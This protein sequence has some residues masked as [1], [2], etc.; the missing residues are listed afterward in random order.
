MAAT[1]GAARPALPGYEILESLGSGGMGEVYR[2]CQESL[3][4]EV[5]VKILRADVPAAGWLPERFEQEAR[6]M[7]GLH[8]PRV[9]TVHDCVRLDD[10]RVAIVMELVGGG[11]L[12][13][14]LNA[15]PN[16]L[17]LEQ[18][19]RW[20]REI[21]EG[22]R[23]AH[24]AGV[25][26]RDV[27]PDNVL[28][29][30]TG[31]ARVSDFGMAFSPLPDAV[32]FTQTGMAAGTPGYMAP[33]LWRGVE[34]DP[35]ADI[36]GYG[37]T[38]YEMLTGRLPQGNFPSARK[39]RPEV[40]GSVDRAIL[41]ALRP[42]PAERPPDMSAM[43]RALAKQPAIT[44][45]HLVAAGA[46]AVFAGGGGWWWRHSQLRSRDTS[47]KWNAIPWPQDP[48]AVA[49]S[50]GWR[51]ENGV[52]YSDDRI[53]IVPLAQ[54]LPASCKL[55]VRFTRLE[56]ELSIGVFIRTLAGTAVCTLDGRAQHLGGV[57]SVNGEVLNPSNS[58]KFVLENGR[59]YDWT[60]EIR[61]GRI[62]MWVDG[63]LKDDRDISGAELSVPDTWAWRPRPGSPALLIGSWNSPT[64]WDW[65]EWLAEEK[66]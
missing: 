63:A 38:L 16:G 6:T 47:G 36:F 1:A 19:L 65:F 27:K 11:S 45:R 61:P 62:R 33:E 48:Q 42:D 7:A 44:R 24:G 9:V 40:P 2:A 15:A 64:R 13:R 4:R 60:I 57:Q 35:R 14:H 8:H 55:R 51:I 18:A 66:S 50:G 28:I 53:C 46:A 30:E 5:A 59:S 39:L 58:F 12:R 22:L 31:S 17:P 3:G 26:H 41:A 20:A 10:G 56:G 52:L 43:L 32:R 34:A 21:A 37:A 49:V 25:V 54:T 29:D 23:A